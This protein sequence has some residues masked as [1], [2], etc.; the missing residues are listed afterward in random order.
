MA[1]KRKRVKKLR[2]RKR[3]TPYN[4]AVKLSS[5][6][7]R[8]IEPQR[9]SLRSY[10]AYFR[11]VLGLPDWQGNPNTLIEGCLVPD[12]GHFFLKTSTWD[13]CEEAAYE[14]AIRFTAERNFRSGK[15][16]Q[17]TKPIRMRE[18]PNEPRSRT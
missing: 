18:L 9:K 16:Y 8:H 3:T 14:E 4:R 15:K 10:D 2:N 1:A 7:L 6:L 17:P 12:T 5:E 13:K 11:R